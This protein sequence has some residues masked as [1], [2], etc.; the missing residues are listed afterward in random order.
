MNLFTICY[1]FGY[2]IWILPNLFNDDMPFVESLSPII[3][4][5]SRKDS[6]GEKMFRL[7]I[8]CFF[9]LLIYFFFINP[10]YITSK[11]NIN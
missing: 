9:A 11:I 3:A 5:Y 4:Y 1:I 8:I 10:D 6:F 2:D 7:G